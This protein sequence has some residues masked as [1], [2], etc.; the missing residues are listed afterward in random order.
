VRC[1][2]NAPLQVKN[3]IEGIISSDYHWRNLSRGGGDTILTGDGSD[4]VCGGPRGDLERLGAGSDTGYGGR[5]N[6]SS[7]AD[8]DETQSSV[9]LGST[10]SAADP[11][12]TRMS[13]KS[14]AAATRPR[15]GL[16][17]IGSLTSAELQ[18]G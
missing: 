7:A 1:E 4:L 2:A 13:T 18:P 15:G 3:F 12:K 8:T 16:T 10:C 6:D 5:G 9:A 11:A 14:Q 17:Q